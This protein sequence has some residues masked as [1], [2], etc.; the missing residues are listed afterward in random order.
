[1]ERGNEI[2]EVKEEDLELIKSKVAKIP[3][4]PKAGIL[5]YDLFSILKDVELHQKTFEIA[6]TLIQNFLIESNQEINAIVG[7]ESRGFLIGLVLADKLK[8]PFVPVR[9][10]NKLPGNILKV[11]YVTEYSQDQL[12]LQADSLNEN[13][14]VLFVDDLLATGGSMRAA[15]DLASM[16]RANVIGYF[17]VFEI[18]AI[19][20]RQKL[21]KPEHLISMIKI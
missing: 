2:K 3:D 21:T 12:E 7:L 16:V 5:F 17:V 10:R 1:M 11:N 9:K 6:V 19:P 8:V 20:G 18:A 4:F 14:K 13:S 15:E